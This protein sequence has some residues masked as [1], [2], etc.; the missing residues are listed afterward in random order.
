MYLY[1]TIYIIIEKN[2]LAFVKK[3][4]Q[5]CRKQNFT[6]GGFCHSYKFKL[7]AA[8]DVSYLDH[9]MYTLSKILKKYIDL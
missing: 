8:G 7:S 3:P 4:P 2:I 9:T 1:T 5:R 6:K